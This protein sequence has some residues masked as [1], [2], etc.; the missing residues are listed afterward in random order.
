MPMTAKPFHAHLCLP[1]TV[2]YRLR[3]TVSKIMCEYD[4]GPGMDAQ[5]IGWRL[6]PCHLAQGWYQIG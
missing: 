5:G 2:L 1:V 3:L 6:V 4:R